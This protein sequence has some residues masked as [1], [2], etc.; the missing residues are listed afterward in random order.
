MPLRKAKSRR[1]PKR[2]SNAFGALHAGGA[3]HQLHEALH[4]GQAQ[5]GAAEL[6]RRRAVCLSKRI[7]QRAN[8]IRWNAHTR[9]GDGAADEDTVRIFLDDVTTYRHLSGLRELDGIAA[10]I[11]EHLA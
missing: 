4:D 3:T 8:A 6:A 11:E 7:E 10:Q 1:E 2:R 5:S 9:V